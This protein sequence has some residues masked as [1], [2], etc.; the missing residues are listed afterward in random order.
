[1]SKQQFT[2]QHN[3]V[4]MKVY[5]KIHNKWVSKCRANKWCYVL[6]ATRCASS[7]DGNH[8]ILIFDSINQHKT[9]KVSQFQVQILGELRS[10]LRMAEG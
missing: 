2:Y 9:I 5:G 7:G 3:V 6:V 10:H 8:V 1:M 4:G